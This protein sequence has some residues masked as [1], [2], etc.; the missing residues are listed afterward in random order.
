M[1]KFLLTAK[2]ALIFYCLLPLLKVQQDPDVAGK[3][4]FDAYV[5][6]GGDFIPGAGG[7]IDIGEEF[8]AC[9]GFYKYRFIFKMPNG[10]T[11]WGQRRS[12]HLKEAGKIVFHCSAAKRDKEMAM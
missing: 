9:E 8:S 5:T 3:V 6:E 11:G 10:D 7:L 1:T 12:F 4:S 2:V